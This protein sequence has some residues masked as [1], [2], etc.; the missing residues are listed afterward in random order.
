MKKAN[1]KKRKIWPLTVVYIYLT[2]R[3]NLKCVHC[4]LDASDKKI[5]YKEPEIK[6]YLR[7]LQQARKLGLG[8]VKISGGEPLLRKKILIELVMKCKEM[9]INSCVE[10][11]ATLITEEIGSA[12]AS[13]NTGVSISMDFID[14]KMH[15]EFRG[16][17]KAF[18]MMEKGLYIL[19]KHNIR[20]EAI[21]AL[22]K[23][24]VCQIEDIIKYLK[25]RSNV[26]EI[27]VNPVMPL[28]RAAKLEEKGLLFK[29]SE[30]LDVS[31][32]LHDLSK[33]INFPIKLHVPPSIRPLSAVVSGLCGGKC[34]FPNL[35]GI[36]GNGNISFCGIGYEKPEFCFGNI[37]SEK[38]D[39]DKIWRTTQILKEI[40]KD[41]PNNLKGVCS[42]CMHK[43]SCKGECRIYAE[44]IYKSFDAPFPTCQNL[45]EE[46]IFPET[47]LIPESY[48]IY[49]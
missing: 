48:G 22:T 35:L 2:E 47:R 15:N 10:T 40:R 39:L 16:S 33:S 34:S 14:P 5:N 21:M 27:K 49:H 26:Y 13:A 6:H 32:K 36:L 9:E 17:D 4:W 19:R 37:Q 43:I 31:Y 29:P 38:L 11:N 41:I 25:N 45:Y 23:E 44:F 42:K 1:M 12:L 3:C 7:F 24:N 46:G 18:E 28:G 30:L 8:L 20:V